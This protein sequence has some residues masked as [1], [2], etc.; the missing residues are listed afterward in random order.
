MKGRAMKKI[1][2]II[3]LIVIFTS[4]AKKEPDVVF[5]TAKDQKVVEVEPLRNK[6][7]QEDESQTQKENTNSEQEE[8]DVEPVEDKILPIEDDSNQTTKNTVVETN[9]T[10]PKK[11]QIQEIKTQKQEIKVPTKEDTKI[12]V[13]EIEI[14]KIIK[15]FKPIKKRIGVLRVTI[16]KK[17]IDIFIKDAIIRKNY[18]TNPNRIV[19]DFKPLRYFKAKSISIDSPLVSKLN[20]ASHEKFNRVVIYVKKDVNFDIKREKKGW[21]VNFL[22]KLEQ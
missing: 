11:P 20:T 17:S 18:L 6:I 22:T 2:F 19:I 8:Q 9:T 13:Q 1:F 3:G 16:G 5:D 7:I 4:C 15:E 10:T 21:R 14:P 12:Q